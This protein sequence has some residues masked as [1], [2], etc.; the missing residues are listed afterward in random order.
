MPWCRV[1]SISLSIM[2]LAVAEAS[3]PNTP[4]HSPL[5][6]TPLSAGTGQAVSS[7]AYIDHTVSEVPLNC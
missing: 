7:V 5:A 2:T 3:S 1:R 6:I 4:H